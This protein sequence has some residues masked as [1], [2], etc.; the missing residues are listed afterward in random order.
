MQLDPWVSPCVLFG[1]WFSPWENWSVWLVDIVVLS[2]GLQTPSPTSVLSLIPPME[3]LCSSQWLAVSTC[4]CTCQALAE[5][6]RRQLD[7]A[8]P[9]LGM[10]PKDAPTYNKDTYS[11]MFIATLFMYF[12]RG[13]DTE[14]VVHLC[15]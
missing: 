15:N 7:Q 11:T 9:L 13:I 5:P 12:N 3:T 2:M 14:N 6:L 4:L 8:R 1:W 10:F